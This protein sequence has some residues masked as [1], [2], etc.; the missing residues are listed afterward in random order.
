MRDFVSEIKNRLSI[1][2]KVDDTYK[3]S[4]N[5]VTFTVN[6]NEVL[7][8]KDNDKKADKKKIIMTHTEMFPY[9]FYSKH[10]DEYTEDELIGAVNAIDGFYTELLGLDPVG[11]S[12]CS[13]YNAL[14]WALLPCFVTNF[15]DEEE[16]KNVQAELLN[17]LAYEIVNKNYDNDNLLIYLSCQDVETDKEDKIFLFAAGL[18]KLTVYLIDCDYE[19]GQIKDLEEEIEHYEFPYSKYLDQTM[20]SAVKKIVKKYYNFKVCNV[21][22]NDDI[23]EKIEEIEETTEE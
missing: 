6:D 15:S 3:V 5:K 9:A 23:S 21:T 19:T 20:L 13:R 7:I 4:K 12:L 10:G 2:Y 14:K 1:L 17:Y 11:Q 16:I 18:D 8:K 22:F